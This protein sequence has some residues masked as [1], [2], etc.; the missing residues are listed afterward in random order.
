MGRGVVEQILIFSLGVLVA[1][2]AWLVLLPAF[3]RRATRITRA[4]IEQSL[5]L[6]PNEIAAEQDRQRAIRAVELGR[7]ERQIEA[8]RQ[9]LVAAKAETGERLRAESTFLDQIDEGRRRIAELQAEGENLSARIADLEGK[10]TAMTSARDTALATI[11]RLESEAK[12]QAKRLAETLDTA[13]NRRIRIDELEGH[14]AAKT[15]A[16]DAET[17]RATNLRL[18][19][20]TVDIHLR[21]ARRE[22]AE[23]TTLV[24]RQT[25]QLGIR[26]DE[27]AAA[28]P[29]D[30]VTSNPDDATTTG[31]VSP[32]GPRKTARRSA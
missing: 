10:L 24:A 25:A 28:T 29:P 32:I 21:E 30:P 5:P 3:W 14:L 31:K 22:L 8:S 27:S 17:M 11:S 23:M 2:L 13:E 15:E 16:L 18:E 19:L 4:A 7:I 6:T 20:Q 26:D 12:A 9:A 1:A